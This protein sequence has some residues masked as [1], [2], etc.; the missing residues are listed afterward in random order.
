M[1]E[2]LSTPS[3]AAAAVKRL[4]AATFVAA[5]IFAAGT[6]Q[7]APRGGG[8]AE[9]DAAQ[10]ARDAADA[11]GLQK[12]IQSAAAD[13]AKSPGAEAQLRI[14]LYNHW[15]GEVADDL[16]DKNLEKSAALAGRAAAELGV[17]AAPDSPRAHA[18][19]GLL[20]GDCIPHTSMGGMRL[21]PRAQKEFDKALELDPLSADAYIGEGIGRLMTPSTFGGSAA[22][23]LELFGKAAEID[24]SSDTAHVWLAQAHQKLGERDRALEEINRALALNSNR[25]WSQM[26]KAQVEKMR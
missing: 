10:N 26:V 23:A 18:L 24:P 5:A 11:P 22:K 13:A 8:S 4:V 17:A 14:A 6:M 12:L 19:L 20:L 1:N 3:I 21:G 16:K 25:R 7:A 2:P 9:N 15:L